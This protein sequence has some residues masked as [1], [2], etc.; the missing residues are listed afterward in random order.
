M[1]REDHVVTYPSSPDQHAY[2][3]LHTALT[4]YY[5]RVDGSTPNEAAARAE[6]VIGDYAHAIRPRPATPAGFDLAA[7]RTLHDREPHNPI[8]CRSR[9]TDEDTNPYTWPCPTATAL[10]ATGRSEWA[11]APSASTTTPRITLDMAMKAIDAGII[12]AEPCPIAG[13]IHRAAH[14]GPCATLATVRFDST[15]AFPSICNAT[16]PGGKTCQR[17]HGHS[18]P[19]HRHGDSVY[20]TDYP[21]RR[22]SSFASHC[23]LNRGHLGPCRPTTTPGD[24]ERCAINS[25]EDRNP[26]AL[27]AGHIH[28]HITFTGYAF[29]NNEPT[30]NQCLNTTLAGQRCTLPMDH[31]GDHDNR[32]KCGAIESN[33]PDGEYP[34]VLAKGHPPI[35]PDIDRTHIDKD[36]DTFR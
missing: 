11:D 26:C 10:G 12:P 4:N 14:D 30:A 18:D 9:C 34:C 35:A 5:A 13:C 28:D 6:N 20:W 8:R 23:I 1:Q 2:N 27:S 3:V 7:A 36:G 19:H 31:D 16:S 24:L 22:T 25:P 21:C 33:D 17:I 32:L 29:I 15:P